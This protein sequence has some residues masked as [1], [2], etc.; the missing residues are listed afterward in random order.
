MNFQVEGIGFESKVMYGFQVSAYTNI[1]A[2]ST[3]QSGISI[4]TLGS[5]PLWGDEEHFYKHDY[6]K[7]A[8]TI[9]NYTFLVFFLPPPKNNPNLWATEL[10][11]FGPVDPTA[12]IDP[13]SQ[14]W[15]MVFVVTGYQTGAHWVQKQMTYSYS[16]DLICP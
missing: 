16:G 14:P 7:W 3:D 8:T 13:G 11:A 15:K 1:G 4:P 10:A 6:A 2:G 9:V 12:T 5:I